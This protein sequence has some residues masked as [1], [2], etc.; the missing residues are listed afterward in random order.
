MNQELLA[1]SDQALR[2]A[3]E[4]LEVVEIYLQS[5]DVYE[6]A[7]ALSLPI[8]EVMSHLDKREVKKFIDAVFLDR[9]YMNR[10]K[11]QKTIDSLIDKKLEELEEAEVG[12]SKDIADLLKLA[13]DFRNGEVKNM[14]NE[15]KTS[16]PLQQ[17]NIQINAY[18]ENY[19][20]LVNSI[21]NGELIR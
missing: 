12:S 5:L 16:A 13:I 17:Q 3:P 21:I 14:Q 6:T 8:E 1:Q 4:S 9:G 10:H 7:N 15:S 18:G 19:K 20:N 11:L 2:I